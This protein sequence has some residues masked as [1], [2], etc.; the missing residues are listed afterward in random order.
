MERVIVGISGASGI[1]Y[2][3]RLLETLKAIGVETHLIMSEWA[4]RILTMET[5]YDP[6]YVGGLAAVRYENRDLAAPV[7]SG[8]FLT[9][10]MVIAP[11]SMKTL[12]GIA[13]GYSQTLLERAAD[14]TIK[15]G[16]ALV[17]MPRET[18]LSPIHLENMLK[19][20]RIGVAIVPPMPAFY[21]KPQSI[22]ELVDH[23]VGKIIDRLGFQHR[24]FRR[25]GEI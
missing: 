4:E 24:L 14:V 21:S 10:G 2:G 13:G 20:A 19:L 12:A 9:A 25:W 17:L 5:D 15:E 7:S 8:S 16:R 18:P 3:V 11:C 23:A 6:Q 22:P 1:I